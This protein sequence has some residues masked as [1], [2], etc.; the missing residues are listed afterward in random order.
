VERG[1]P[2]DA[3]MFGP[4]DTAGVVKKKLH[5]GYICVRER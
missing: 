2:D 4:D 5:L 1:D 3:A